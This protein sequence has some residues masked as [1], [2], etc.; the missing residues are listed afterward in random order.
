M[1]ILE[2][3]LYRKAKL[4]VRL[5]LLVFLCFPTAVKAQPSLNQ[6][7]AFGY[8]LDLQF[9]SCRAYLSG[10][11]QQPYT[12]YL[13]QLL[14]SSEVFLSDDSEI[15]KSGKRFLDESL[16]QIE[17]SYILPEQKIFLEAE[18]RIQWAILKMKYGDEFSAFWN[19]RQAYLISRRN[20]ELNPAFIP[21]YKSMGMLYV[22]FG[23]VPEKYDWLLSIFGIR[24]DTR[25]GLN[26]INKVVKADSTYALE[27]EIIAALLYSYI[28]NDQDEGMERL[29][30]LVQMHDYLL[31]D[32]AFALSA[33]KNAKSAEALGLLLKTEEK[34]KQTIKLV[35]IYYLL[36]EIHLQKGELSPAFSYYKKF[37]ENQQGKALIKDAY[38]KMGLCHLIAGD[39]NLAEN[40]FKLAR[41]HGWAK[42]EADKYAQSQIEAEQF[43]HPSLYQLR[44]ATDGGFYEKAF[45][46]QREIHPDELSGKDICEFHYRT[47]RLMQKTD[48][49]D[50][51][52]ERFKKV[53][54]IQGEQN[55]YFAPN[56]ALMLGLMYQKV[57]RLEESKKHLELVDDYRDYPYEKSIRQKAKAAIQDID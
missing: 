10:Y 6:E 41:E 45:D 17:D 52:I 36:G 16:A 2:N 46:I 34:Y 20:I 22:L 31:T 53:I 56:A 44:F 26:Y 11:G 57:D 24:G 35:Q 43:S 8:Y 15:Y 33:I 38:Y 49:W 28:L 55:W 30:K 48:N 19:L 47:A 12:L 37:I 27:G 9:D 21:S 13:Q 7:I 18:V 3:M 42:N 4:F 40:F 32:Y 23:I 50:M 39:T 5:F 25:M 54:S 29:S 1:A 51:A 14:H